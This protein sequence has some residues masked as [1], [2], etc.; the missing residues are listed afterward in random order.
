MVEDDKSWTR[1]TLR[2]PP[3]LH[4]RLVEHANGRSLNTTILKLLEAALGADEA[5]QLK[6]YEDVRAAVS[7]ELREELRKVLAETLHPM[8]GKDEL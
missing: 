1:L 3:H 4:Q 7:K 8:G 2:L 6:S 5:A